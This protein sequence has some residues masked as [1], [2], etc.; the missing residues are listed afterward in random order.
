MAQVYIIQSR[1]IHHFLVRERSGPAQRVPRPKVGERGWDQCG[2][3]PHASLDKLSQNQGFP[4]ALHALRMRIV[5]CREK[6]E[7]VA[8]RC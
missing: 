4:G 5:P 3:R 6:H 7:L 8:H 2:T 1:R